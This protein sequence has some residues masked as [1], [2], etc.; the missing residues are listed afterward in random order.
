MLGI[1]LHSAYAYDYPHPY[2]YHNNTANQNN[3]LPVECVCAQYSECGCD[4]NTDTSYIDSVANNASV[5]TVSEVN[6]T[7]TL[8]INGTLPNG[9]T[10]SGG[11]DSAAGSLRQGLLEGSGWWVVAAG[12]VYTVWLM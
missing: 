6:G 3:T 8:V 9:T 12:V 5:A 1:G 7:K 4:N 11:T 2:T 10:A